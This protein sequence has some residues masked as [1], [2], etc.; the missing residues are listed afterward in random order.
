V[1]PFTKD[2][3]GGAR[4][5]SPIDPNLTGSLFNFLAG[6]IGQGAT[7]FN[8]SSLLP[9]SGTA[10]QP[11]QL[12]AGL[13]PLMEML[14]NFFMTGQGGTPGLD[15]LSQF[16]KGIDVLPSFNAISS[17]MD[18]NIA[19]GRANLAEQFNVG[20]GLVGSPYGTAEAD[21]ENQ[22]SKDKSSILAQLYQNTLGLQE[23]AASTLAGAGQNFAGALQG[24]DQASIDRLLQEFIR[25][26]PEYSPLLGAEF[27]A[28][29]TF[30]PIFS[31]SKGQS[32]LGS[33]FQ[34]IPGIL[35]SLGDAGLL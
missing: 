3:G 1:N 9:S 17:A 29:T 8:L 15:T 7:P 22:A 25:T 21:Y 32:S 23:G 5:I 31:Q 10:T 30:P 28:A 12:T 34:S 13:N 16:S 6:Q 35:S 20:G 19:E 27:G 18:R 4:A 11:G 2:I 14:K 33:L 26:R 24:I